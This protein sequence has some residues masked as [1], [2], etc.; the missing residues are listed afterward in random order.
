MFKRASGIEM[1][2]LI[3]QIGQRPQLFVVN[4]LHKLNF[5]ILRKISEFVNEF[6]KK[7][8]QKHFLRWP[9]K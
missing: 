9:S 6:L 4:T 8:L 1:S 5:T 7:A 2:P 3:I